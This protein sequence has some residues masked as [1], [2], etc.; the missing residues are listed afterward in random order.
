M[1]YWVKMHSHLG[2]PTAAMHFTRNVAQE[3][4]M[5]MGI[6]TEGAET[7]NKE[8]SKMPDKFKQQLRW[9][10]FAELVATY[11]SHQKEGGHTPLNCVIQEAQPDVVT[12]YETTEHDEWI[13][14]T[15][16]VLGE[17]Y[18]GDND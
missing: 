4:M 2:Q 11:V 13:I 17:V 3:Y 6:N 8:V 10:V 12:V 18:E 7:A 16:P 5:K 14:N 15:I 1:H 9:L